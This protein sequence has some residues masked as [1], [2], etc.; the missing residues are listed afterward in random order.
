VKLLR[1]LI[2]LLSAP[3]FSQVGIGTTN[4]QAQLDIQASSATAPLPTDG[5][6]IPK[7][8]VFPATNPTIAQ[9]S[10][11]VYLT[12]ASGTYIPGF[13]YWDHP[14]LS[15]KPLGNDGSGKDWQLT[16]NSGTID[17]THFIGTTDNVPLRFRVNNIPSG[18]IQSESPFATS[19][20]YGALASNTTGYANTAH[21]Y[22]ALYN[23]T[24]GFSNTATG[25]NALYS[26]T[27]G[28][29]NTATGYLA[30][31]RNTTG[32]GHT[33]LGYQ[34]LYSN[35]SG[36]DNAAHGYNTLYSNTT[37]S[38]N[39]ATGGSALYYNTTG[40]WN[41]A[42]GWGALYYNT[43]GNSNTA[44]G[45]LALYRNTTGDA[46]TA[47]GL[48]ALYNNTIGYNNTAHGY[49]ALYNNTTGDNN[50]A[51]GYTSLFNNT[52]G[53]SNTAIGRSA[54]HAN[55]TGLSNTAIGY[56]SLFNNTT[57]NNNTATGR[58]ALGFNTTGSSNTAH[59]YNTLYSNTTG[60]NNTALG[61]QAY[62]TGIF[63]NS[64]ALGS[65]T[66]ITGNN[67]IRLGNNV[68]TSIGGFT[69]WTN[70]SDKRFKKDIEEN[71]PGL[72]FITQLRPV[73]YH[74]DM[75]AIAK[76]LEIPEESRDKESEK[77]K[78]AIVQSG[79]IAQE[80][81]LVCKALGYDFSGVDAPKNNGDFY[82][83][84]YAEFVVPLVKAVQEQN[85]MLE[86][87]AIEIA[88]LKTQLEALSKTLKTLTH[89]E[90]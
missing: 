28:N 61:Y 25:T 16:G 29:R 50:T 9:N 83:L 74:L 15:W 45:Y 79:F 53:N 40:R 60:N 69:G 76:L 32:T 12:T 72:A 66:A 37:G 21:G 46:N 42:T 82:G 71:V 24:T 62:R 7:V 86:L 39:T 52:I 65:G 63:T 64:T 59:G 77:Q 38:S 23:N 31:Y 87:Q 19:F 49:Q 2:L 70:V 84:R 81:A 78:G 18:I 88:M 44:T 11:L 34:A 56:T 33:A 80:V 26:N 22:L 3:C 75:E 43:T 36:I 51:I 89:K 5:L 10:L 6:L 30:L 48:E 27:T 68:V 58:D 35:T 41:T 20:G 54:L 90:N 4:P 47:Q 67:Q 85:A 73:S 14:S 55:T 1:L 13:Y 57:G 8:N 17:G